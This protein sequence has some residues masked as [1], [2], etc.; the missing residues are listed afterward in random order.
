MFKDKH[1]VITGG[2]SGLGLELARMLTDSGA[3]VALMARDRGKLE[4]AAGE[5][6]QRNHL[7]RVSVI[8]VDVCD[9]SAAGEAMRRTAEA[10]DGI[11]ML[12]NSAGILREGY[13]ETLPMKAFRD[14]MEINY[15]GILH[16]TR[17]AL[18]YLKASRGRLVN[19][20]SMAGLTGVFG[21]TPYCAS[22]HALVGLSE[23]LRY[24]LAPAGVTVHLVCPG[25]FD[26]PMVDELDRN[27]TPEN[28]A[29]ALTIPKV[30]V[31]TVADA[32]VAGIRAG[33]FFIV[34]GAPTRLVAFAIRHFPALT[35]AL[36]DRRIA[37]ASKGR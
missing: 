9:E 24:E 26:S 22:K 11:D 7:A 4:Q 1:V 12:I 25:E 14:V 34:P 32:T 29:H 3:R 23:S 28:R 27:R 19:I 15:F 30:S 31:D 21:Y 37:A 13:F 2:S 36:G 8:P 33:R 16:A 18:P 5:L 35:R 20:A 6:Q 10:G 17:A